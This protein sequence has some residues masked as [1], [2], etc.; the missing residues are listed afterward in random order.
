MALKTGELISEFNPHCTHKNVGGGWE[1]ANCW[2]CFWINIII[3]LSKSYILYFSKYMYTYYLTLIL[4]KSL[5]GSLS[6]Y[7][8]PWIFF[9]LNNRCCFLVVLL[10]SQARGGGC[11]LVTKLCPTPLRLKWFPR[12]EYW[13]GLLFPSPGDW[14]WV[15][16]IG[17]RFFT[18]KPPEPKASPKSVKAKLS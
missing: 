8:Y 7:Y 17:G 12:Q 16:C 9:F 4:A 18:T 6:K 5:W 15:S 14:T 1:G 2:F 13:S 10:F 11:C 3:M